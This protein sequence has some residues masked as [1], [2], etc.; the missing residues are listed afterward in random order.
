MGRRYCMRC[1][2]ISTHTASSEDGIHKYSLSSEKV[3]NTQALWSLWCL[4]NHASSFCN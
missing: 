1:L 2:Q 3:A 4:R